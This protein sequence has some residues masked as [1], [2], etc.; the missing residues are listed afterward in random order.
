MT[1]TPPPTSGGPPGLPGSWERRWDG[2]EVAPGVLCVLAPNESAMTHEGTNT[3]LLHA[4]GA[5]EAVVVDPG[6]QLPGHL[7]AVIA[8]ARER[9]VRI[10][11]ILVTHHH[12]DHLEG[13]ERFAQLTGAPV[14]FPGRDRPATAEETAEETAE[15]TAPTFDIEVEGLRVVAVPTPGHT[16]DSYCFHVPQLGAL[17]TG[18]TILGRGTTVVTW[19][20]GDL[21]AYLASLA[22]LRD[23]AT[24]PQHPVEVIL[25]GH[26]APFSGADVTGVIDYYLD[27][28]R[29][30]LDQVR[31]VLADRPV[32]QADDDPE[33]GELEALVEH[34]VRTVYQ[35]A[36]QEV[37]PAARQ[38]VRAQLEYLRSH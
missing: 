35:D 11:A 15:G 9:G 29:E 34:V 23:L 17:L 26:A 21:G 32:P 2:G 10:A 31:A 3:W 24:D 14:H 36:P 28:R 20:D 25:P 7:D 4:P 19:P 13:V 5:G 33:A 1:S 22:R 37:W 27:H 12:L 8:A 30:R 16:M 18:D 6:P 38:S